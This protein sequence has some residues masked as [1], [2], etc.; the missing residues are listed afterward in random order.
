MQVNISTDCFQHIAEALLQ[1]WENNPRSQDLG[2]LDI[3]SISVKAPEG[4]WCLPSA[5]Y[6]GQTLGVFAFLPSS[7][8]LET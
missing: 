4:T 2:T 3:L 8:K 7:E 6:P 1:P 5:S